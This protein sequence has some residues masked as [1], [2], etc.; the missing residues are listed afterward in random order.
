MDNDIFRK[1]LQQQADGHQLS[2][3]EEAQLRQAY[4][5]L[6]QEELAATAEDPSLG[7]DEQRG[8]AM[9]QRIDQSIADRHTKRLRFHPIRRIAAAAIL[10]GMTLLAGTYWFRTGKPGNNEQ[11]VQQEDILP[12]AHKARLTLADGSAISLNDAKH[13]TI[14][15]QGGV[16]IEKDAEGNIRYNADKK[17]TALSS[18]INTITTPN[19]GQY[20]V[21]LPDNSIAILNAASSLSYP[22]QFSDKERRVKMTG[23]VYFEIEKMP[24]PGG[25]GNVPF[26]VETAGQE[27]QVLGTHFDINAYGNETAIRTTLVEG[28]VKVRSNDGQSALLK[29]GQQAVLAKQLNVQQADIQQQ[30][31]WVNGDFVFRGETLENILRQVER[32]YDIEVE[33]PPH[34]G[35]MRFNGMVS[36]SQPLSAIIRMIQSTKKATVTVK[37]RR[38]IV[39]D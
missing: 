2:P 8:I 19:G 10:V 17:P 31:A 39:T 16:R 13:G 27:V 35:K 24:M 21:T 1:L 34:I 37:K 20:R 23:E 33:Y 30:L 18:A 7:P 22:V 12:G 29:P 11:L 3:E 5:Q 25:K 14:A 9:R 38:F 15:T 6:L 4:D 36:R 26:F 28:S 32:W